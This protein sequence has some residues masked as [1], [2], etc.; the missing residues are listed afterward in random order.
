[1]EDIGIYALG[2]LE[3]E[4]AGNEADYD[5]ARPIDPEGAHNIRTC[6]SGVDELNKD[7]T[8]HFIIGKRGVS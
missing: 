7:V 4:A 8:T 3:M 1:M 5:H 2:Y 6:L